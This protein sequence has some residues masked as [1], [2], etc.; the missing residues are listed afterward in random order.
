[1]RPMRHATAAR[2]IHW[3]LCATL[4]LISALAAAGDENPKP[5][6]RSARVLSVLASTVTIDA[7]RSHGLTVGQRLQVLR[8][9]EPVAEVEATF[10]AERSA[11]C[12]VVEQL[13]PILPGDQVS[14]SAAPAAPPPGRR[15]GTKSA[16]RP[17]S[18]SPPPSS[19]DQWSHLAGTVSLDWQH[20]ADGSDRAR[21]FDQATARVDL[22]LRE[23]GGSPFEM[24]VR[25]R[26]REN[27]IAEAA[28]TLS[29]R[30]DRLYELALTYE[31]P[32][33]RLFLQMG[34]LRSGPLVG[35]DYLDGI[36][37][38]VRLKPRFGIGAFYGTRSNV[39][40]LGLSSGA[41]TYGAFFHYQRERTRESP[42]YADILIGGVGEY[43]SGE[44]NREYLSIYG[45]LGSASRWTLYHRAD[46]DFHRGWRQELA[47]DSYQVSNLVVSGTYQVSQ[48]VRLGLS[49]DQRRRYR[50]L[51]SRDTPEER[52]DSRLRDGIRA[53]LYLGKARGLRATLSAG[54]RRL[55]GTSEDSNTL[56]AS[57]YHTDVGAWNLLLAADYSHFSSAASE[58]QRIGL[59]ARK[60]FR[61]GHDVGLTLGASETTSMLAGEVRQNRWLRL[62]GNSRLPRSFFVLWEV[63]LDDGDDLAGVRSTLRLGYR[64]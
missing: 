54:Q 3:G 58:G 1:M 49:Y 52:F 47:G 40:E 16:R 17:R 37:G 45:R 38:E 11:S 56:A 60:Y 4:P 55:E 24:S 39:D 14:F 26:G 9:G 36:L 28:G 43:E 53:T 63:E 15:Q 33:G 42:F 35:F 5:G 57:L 27:R 12:H 59:Q 20:F 46:V 41:E 13:E 25:V 31:P 19:G 23:I 48:A 7:G 30:R 34:R 44:V 22:R 50:D 61:G 29:E 21:D 18:P 8:D 6:E 62:S 64:L 32:E 10:V 2:A 51:E